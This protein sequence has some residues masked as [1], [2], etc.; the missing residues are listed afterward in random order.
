MYKAP[1]RV[2]C[3]GLDNPYDS[4]QV[5][6]ISD[7]AQIWADYPNAVVLD[8]RADRIPPEDLESILGW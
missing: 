2:Y 6:Y 1:Y 7:A 8:D 4:V 5:N 3:S